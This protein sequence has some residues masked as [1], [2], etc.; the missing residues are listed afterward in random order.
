MNPACVGRALV[1]MLY[2]GSKIVDVQVKLDTS[3]AKFLPAVYQKEIQN[4]LN[5]LSVLMLNYYVRKTF[6]CLSV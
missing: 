3:N 5:D 2:G 4:L 6:L 1:Q